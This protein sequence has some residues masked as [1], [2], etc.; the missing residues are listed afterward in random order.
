M[1]L[2]KNSEFHIHIKH[3]DIKYH[4]IHELINEDIIKLIY[5]FTDQMSADELTK[6]LTLIKFDSFLVLLC[7][8]L[9][10]NRISEKI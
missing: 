8:N 2:A 6:L 9:E 1:Q 3:I 4:W 10:E 5:I 7:M